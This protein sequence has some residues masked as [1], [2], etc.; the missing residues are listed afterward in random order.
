MRV[1]LVALFILLVS[2]SFAATEPVILVYGDSLSAGYG[3][4]RKDSWVSL[5]EE[6]LRAGKFA[7]RVVN[8]SI[9]GE[10][11]AGGVSRIGS[12]LDRHRPRILLLAL[13]A[14]DGLRGLPVEEMRANLDR[15]LVA[16]RAAGVRVLL[17]GM[18]LPPN[19]GAA[20]TRA[21][22]AAFA[23]LARRHRT[24]F[25]PFLL[26]GFADRHEYFQADGLHPNAQA[27]PLIAETV[28]PALAPLLTQ[29]NRPGRR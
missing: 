23:D 17:V 18:R 20:Y 1:F 15:I 10:T 5:L 24:A 12:A 11:S 16:A 22:H 7:H 26:E 19:Y 27:Q 2:P 9:S 3:L 6:R 14:N 28:W 8:A 21:F 4:A 25:I 29:D 13:G